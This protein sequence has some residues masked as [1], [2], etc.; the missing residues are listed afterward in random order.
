MLFRSRDPGSWTKVD[1]IEIRNVLGPIIF[2]FGSVN[3]QAQRRERLITFFSQQTDG[4]L[5]KRSLDRRRG[6]CKAGVL[7]LDIKKAISSV[8]KN[9]F[10]AS[11]RH[12]SRPGRGLVQFLPV[13]DCTDHNGKK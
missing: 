5:W 4:R 3:A 7:W 9:L 8:L 1:Q 13:L 2:I 10:S 12:P 11:Y 6:I